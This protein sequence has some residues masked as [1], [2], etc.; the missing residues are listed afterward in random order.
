ME[1][2]WRKHVRRGD[3]RF[4][5]LTSPP[6]SLPLCCLQ[7]GEVSGS[8]LLLTCWLCPSGILSQKWTLSSLAVVWRF[9]PRHSKVPN[10][11]IGGVFVHHVHSC[12]I[13][14]TQRWPGSHI[15]TLSF[16]CFLQLCSMKARWT[17][18]QW[19]LS[20]F[21]KGKLKVRTHHASGHFVSW[22]FY[23]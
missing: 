6:V 21:P 5:S 11:A 23:R 18:T 16:L 8:S 19:L 12:I 13:H 3:L 22:L 7:V 14:C 15:H 20:H 9:D 1:P 17:P 2:C 4:C 10:T